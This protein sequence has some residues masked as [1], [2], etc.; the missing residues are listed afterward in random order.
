MPLPLSP[1]TVQRV[2]ALFDA[3]LYDA[4]VRLLEDECGTNL[5]FCEDSTASEMERIRYAA[6]RLSDGTIEGLHQAVDLAKTDWRDLLMAA[7]SGED[8]HAHNR[9]FPNPD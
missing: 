5:P 3:P 8:I 6:L 4:A 7:G 2:E 9:W 1:P